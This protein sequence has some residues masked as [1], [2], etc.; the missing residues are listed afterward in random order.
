[1]QSVLQT[2]YIYDALRT[3]RGRA[4]PDGVLHAFTPFDL[5]SC[6]YAALETRSALDPLLIDD[7]V[8]GC[9]TQVGEQA[10][11]IAKTSTLYH[12]WPGSVP[13][14]TVNRYCSSGLDAICI[15]ASKILCGM[16]Q[17]SI[18][19][20]VEMMSR[21]AMLSDN[22][23]AF[24]DTALASR[25]GMFMMGVGADYIATAHSVTR[26]E[27][28]ALALQSQQR[29]QH[30]RASGFFKSLIPLRAA[31][32]VAG[33]IEAESGQTAV[34]ED[35]TIRSATTAQS[36]AAMQPAFEAASLDGVAKRLL[37][38]NFSGKGMAHVHT[39]G[40]SP[41]MADGASALLLG[42]E[43]AGK[44][45]RRGPRAKIVQMVTV[46]ADPRE[47][48]SGCVAATSELLRRTNL[49][50]DA[51]DLFEIH[52]AF[53]ATM[54]YGARRLGIDNDKLNVN[55]GCI[56]LGHPLGATGG[57]IVSTLL[58]ELER[59]NLRTG[60]AA[61]SG[62]AGAGTAMLIQRC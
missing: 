46:N 50:A 26:E 45:L 44:Q 41:A 56:A 20:G 42:S 51:I 62:A 21:V 19:G 22:P 49:H 7:V 48:V 1:M 3:P 47:V 38:E 40:N 24:T 61:T 29:A 33:V 8:L 12:G 13:G 52:E 27:A 53:A 43:Q 54:V 31:S 36:L 17:L 37:H 5:L 10:A 25:L 34:V 55:G 39:A 23:L 18:A 14:I 11:N 30:A 35:E 4:R 32:A 57:I 6:L 59:R 28:D 60:V 58:D 2:A 9:A 15:A 16:Q